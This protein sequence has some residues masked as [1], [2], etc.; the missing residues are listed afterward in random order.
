LAPGGERLG[1]VLGVGLI[2]AGLVKLLV[3][4]R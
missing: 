4:V 3:L 1:S 2:A